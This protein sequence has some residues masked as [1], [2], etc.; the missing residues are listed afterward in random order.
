MFSASLHSSCSAFV[1][2]PHAV[3]RLF[4]RAN[5]VRN[6]VYTR[7][8]QKV[9]GPTMKEQRYE[10][11]TLDQK[12]LFVHVNT[13]QGLTFL[14]ALHQS[15]QALFEG[16]GFEPIQARS[17]R[18]PSSPRCRRKRD[19]QLFL[20]VREK[21]I[22][23]GSRVR[24]IKRVRQQLKAAVCRFVH[25]YLVRRGVVPKQALTFGI[26]YVSSR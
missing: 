20:H 14:T 24:R 12:C 23:G 7:G 2:P 4:S 5:G 18:M 26:C 1:L 21:V 10:L 19:R 16:M 17:G 9:L 22:V 13:V 25:R 6:A 8:V 11:D 3:R 15:L